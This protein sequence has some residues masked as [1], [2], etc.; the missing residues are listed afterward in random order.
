MREKKKKIS[1]LQNF[2]FLTFWTLQSFP[3]V[4][5]ILQILKNLVDFEKNNAKNATLYWMQKIVKIKFLL[6]FDKFYKIL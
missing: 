6:K 5:K 3:I 1:Q 4:C 2:E